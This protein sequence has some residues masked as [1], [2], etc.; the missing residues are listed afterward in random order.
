[1]TSKRTLKN[2]AMKIT[3]LDGRPINWKKPPAPHVIV[4]WTKK[5]TSGRSI[6]G[7][8]RTICHM[9]RLNRLAYL[10][11]GVGISV[12][13]PDWNTGVAASA[14]THDFDATWDLWIPGVDPWVQQRFFRRNGLGGWMRKPPL[15]GWHYHGFT[16]PPREG[17]SIS[18]DFRVHKFKV[19][20]YVDGGYSTFGRLVTSSQ[21]SDYYNHAFGLS[22]AH[23][24]GSDRT[25]FP[26]DISATIFDLKRFVA[27]RV[28][29]QEAA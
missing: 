7:S 2:Y 13:Q 17:K 29:E 24:P 10:R 14:G 23:T 27:N 19:G 11:W 4:R 18:D 5:T 9:D 20:K 1:M 22:G 28:R 26:R 15:F 12:I 25:W 8:F 3:Y 16:L 21:I 6:K